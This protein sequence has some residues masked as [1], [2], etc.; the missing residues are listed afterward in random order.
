MKDKVHIMGKVPNIFQTLLAPSLK[1]VNRVLHDCV[2]R[3][4]ETFLNVYFV[5]STDGSHLLAR[6]RVRDVDIGEP[7]RLH[8]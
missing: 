6:L 2:K 7:V 8:E 5:V 4:T 3:E 1:R